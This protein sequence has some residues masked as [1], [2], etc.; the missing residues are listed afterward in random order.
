MGVTV[1][2]KMTSQHQVMESELKSF[3]VYCPE[4][5]TKEGTVSYKNMIM[6][7]FWAYVIVPVLTKFIRLTCLVIFT[8]HLEPLG[9]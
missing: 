1:Q 8:H 9:F 2:M 4:L 3:F 5:G 7:A 6:H